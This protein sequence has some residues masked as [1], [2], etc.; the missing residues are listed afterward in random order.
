MSKYLLMHKDVEV[1]VL[2]FTEDGHLSD[3]CDVL[4]PSHLPP[5]AEKEKDSLG[6][7][8]E[9]RAVPKSRKDIRKLLRE[10]QI[11]TTGSWLLDNLALSLYDCYWVKPEKASLSWKDV[12]LYDNTFPPLKAG[13]FLTDYEENTE[14]HLDFTPDASTG[15]ELPKWW[16]IENGKRYLIK[17][18]RDGNSIQSRNEILASSIHF[19]QGFPHV[20]YELIPYVYEG[21]RYTGCRCETFSSSSLEF[22]PAWNLITRQKAAENEPYR[23]IFIR[24]CRDNGF[25]ED[26][27]MHFLDYMAI[28]DFL[29]SNR[30]RHFNNFGL[31]RNPD[32]LEYVSFAPLFDSGNSMMYY[33]LRQCSMV[34]SLREKTTGFYTSWKTT[35]EHVTDF[36]AVDISRLPDEKTIEEI[37]PEKELGNAFSTSLRNLFLDHVGF[38]DG[39]RSG[40]SFYSLQ[41]MYIEQ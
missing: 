1:A 24:R 28:T 5:S 32:T 20:R 16:I 39:L 27:I 7:W 15:G 4:Y 10:Q 9:N 13:G 26:S 22:I 8:W 37:Y 31:M 11:R 41:K 30:D 18:N 25:S 33:Y 40:K 23:Q 29:I 38:L 14:K 17:G 21:L 12:N 35:M 2:L 3:V 34:N 6:I 36:N 19:L